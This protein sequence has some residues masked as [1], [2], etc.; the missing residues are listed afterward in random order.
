MKYT[1]WAHKKIGADERG[2]AI[3]IALLTLLI[4]TI[5]GIATMN[6]S[7]TE[8]IVATS[9]ILDKMAFEE[10]DGGVE[11]AQKMIEVS[12]P[13]GYDSDNDGSK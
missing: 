13:D 12:I 5:I 9:D 10:A 4:V 6:E 7:I 11:V 3:V 2:S 8:K 1:D